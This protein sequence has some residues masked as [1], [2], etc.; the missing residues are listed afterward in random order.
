MLNNESGLTL[1]EL[2]L[3]M[4]ILGLVL[5]ASTPKLARSFKNLRSKS[6]AED[7]AADLVLCR[8]RAILSGSARR[9]RVWDNGLGY[10]VERLSLESGNRPSLRSSEA[11]QVEIDNPMATETT[12]SPPGQAFEWT[13]AGSQTTGTLI[14]TDAQNRLFEIRMAGKSVTIHE[15]VNAGE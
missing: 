10:T 4:L 13:P 14:L 1:I 6:V 8:H 12:L 9:M 7:V 5:M 3:T 2:C 15:M 11:W